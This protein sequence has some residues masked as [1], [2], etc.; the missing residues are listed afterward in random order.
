MLAPGNKLSCKSVTGIT[1][2]DDVL[3]TC[4]MN[5]VKDSDLKAERFSVWPP[6]AS[7]TSTLCFSLSV[8]ELRNLKLSFGSKFFM[9][10][11]P[12]DDGVGDINMLAEVGVLAVHKLT[13][14][15]EL[16][17]RGTVILTDG[18]PKSFDGIST[19]SLGL[20]P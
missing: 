6:E 9:E 3:L 10:V 13:S 8:A 12:L 11:L 20:F 2:R 16:G 17:L 19:E 7:G 4:G 15:E 5:L 1:G 18:F 14:V